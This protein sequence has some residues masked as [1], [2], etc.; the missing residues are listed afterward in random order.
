MLNTQKYTKA[1]ML[2]YFHLNNDNHYKRN[3]TNKLEL[4]GY[5]Y[6]Y[7]KNFITITAIPT[8][9]NQFKELLIEDLH[10]DKK[11][12][13]IHIACFIDAFQ[14]P[15]FAAMPWASRLV[16]INNT[17]NIQVSMRT[18]QYWYQK[19]VNIEVIQ[20][21]PSRDTLWKTYSPKGSYERIQQ[22]VNLNNE[23]EYNAY[24]QW[25]TLRNQLSESG[26]NNKEL[27]Y[28]LWEKT[29]TCYYYCYSS[30]LVSSYFNSNPELIAVFYAYSA[31]IASKQASEKHTFVKGQ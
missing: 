11:V 17:Y 18:L 7:N 25:K 21:T 16:Y 22:Q 3:I 31:E 9:E 19:L 13:P 1:E 29:K 24:E 20:R 23:Q 2:N 27:Y 26:I 15:S 12:N 10:Y 14:E 6:I 4:Y 28:K 5:Q 30:F 8:I